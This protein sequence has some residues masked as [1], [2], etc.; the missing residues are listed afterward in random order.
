[1][2]GRSRRGWGG[3]GRRWVI[4][5]ASLGAQPPHTSSLQA[6]QKGELHVHLN[7]L[8]SSDAIR[9]ILAD[10]RVILPTNFDP[11]ID[12]N[13]TSRSR[14]LGEYLKPWEALRLI[15]S[16][17]AGLEMLCDNAFSELKAHNIQFVELRNSVIYLASLRRT[18]V[19]L[20]LNELLNHLSRAS[21]KHSIPFGLLLT[22]TRGDYSEVQLSTL[23]QAY[24]ELGCPS[25][26]VGIDLAGNEDIDVPLGLADRFRWAKERFGLGVTVHAG[27]TGNANNVR[28]AVLRY[29]ADRIGHGTAVGDD[30]RLLQLL[31]K[32]DVCLEV[33]P[34][35]NRLT[36]AVDEARS[37]P[38]ARFLTEGVPFVIC[39]DNPGIHRRGLTE[40]Y[41]M[42]IEETANEAFLQAQ[43]ATAR[44]YSF[45]RFSDE[46]QIHF[47][48]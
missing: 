10:E 22:V 1:M 2:W 32:Q 24:Q 3:W 44:R 20:A 47:S 21:T 17:D 42:F 40:D 16:T 36:G 38:M 43:Y 5:D 25:A 26:V 28:D 6:I 39:A 48:K 27:E 31:K 29:G 8:V 30:L 11:R 18:S 7:G 14:T 45:M 37:H 33:C 4:G 13:R 46:N 34:I 41:A 23:L 35:S 12:L 19:S 15:P 9:R